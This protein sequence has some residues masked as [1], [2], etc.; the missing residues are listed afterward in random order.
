[1]TLAVAIFTQQEIEQGTEDLPKVSVRRR[2][3][4]VRARREYVVPDAPPE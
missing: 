4:E 1:M 3:V 2:G